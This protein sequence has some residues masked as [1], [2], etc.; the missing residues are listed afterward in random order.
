MK[1]KSSLLL[2]SLLVLML[3]LIGCRTLVPQTVEVKIPTLQAFRPPLAPENLIE[4]PQTSKDVL[5]NSVIFEFWA[6]EWQDYA[7]SLEDQID[8]IRIEITAPP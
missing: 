1:K 7:M 2:I 3:V 4:N 6:Y 5:H 8:G